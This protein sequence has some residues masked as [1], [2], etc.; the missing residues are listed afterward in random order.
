MLDRLLGL[1]GGWGNAKYTRLKAECGRYKK[2]TGER[3]EKGE[4]FIR[5]KEKR[6]GLRREIVS[7]PGIG[8][9]GDFQR[10][11]RTTKQVHSWETAREKV[12]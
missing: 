7:N 6:R 10:W 11:K 3:G 12:M 9:S 2:N 1:R 8:S 4:C 5:G